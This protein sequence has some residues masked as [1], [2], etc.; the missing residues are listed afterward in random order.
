MLCRE[1]YE[2]YFQD[3]RKPQQQFLQQQALAQQ[4][5]GEKSNRRPEEKEELKPS[6]S[7]ADK[8]QASNWH[9]L[10]QAQ[11]RSSV[12]SPSPYQQVG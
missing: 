3:V 10:Q 1:S 11:K 6:S 4:A 2:R 7:P 8:E 12:A 9:Q 5:Q